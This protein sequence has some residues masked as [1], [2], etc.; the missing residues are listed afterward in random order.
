MTNTQDTTFTLNLFGEVR[1]VTAR[2]GLLYDVVHI[3][4]FVGTIGAGTARYPTSLTLWRITDDKPA[5][6]GNFTVTAADG[7]VWQSNRTTVIRNRQAQIVGWAD[8]AGVTN[9]QDQTR[10]AS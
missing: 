10:T 3:P 1:T 2:G 6:R 5:Y 9:A 4:G 8:T 7:S